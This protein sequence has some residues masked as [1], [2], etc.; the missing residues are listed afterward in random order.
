MAAKAPA[1]GGQMSVV[2]TELLT[3]LLI[4]VQTLQV[5]SLALA[6]QDPPAEIWEM[7]LSQFFLQSPHFQTQPWPSSD[8]A[9]EGGGRCVHVDEQVVVWTPYFVL[10]LRLCF[11]LL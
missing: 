9:G 3:K 2:P 5:G 11:S 8:L 7:W 6:S 4:R 10:G 1:S